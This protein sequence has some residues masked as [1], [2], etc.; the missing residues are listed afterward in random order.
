[1]R[2]PEIAIS[3]RDVGLHYKRTVNRAKYAA[4]GAAFG[5]TL[6]GVVNRD[7]ASTGG[8][9]GALVGATIGERRVSAGAIVNQLK[10]RKQANRALSARK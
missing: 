8:A 4:I 2:M 3:K 7:A 1:M 10:E 9:L 5:A 6:G